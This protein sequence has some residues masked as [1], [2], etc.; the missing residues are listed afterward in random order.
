MVSSGAKQRLRN[1]TA[2]WFIWWHL[3]RARS[4]GTLAVEKPGF[5]LAIGHGSLAKTALAPT[6]MWQPIRFAPALGRGPRKASHP[7]HTKVRD[8]KDF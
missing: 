4:C 6:S 1:W 8:Y 7:C 2:G 5:S 3:L